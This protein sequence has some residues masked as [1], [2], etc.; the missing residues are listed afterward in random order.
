[1]HTHTH[2]HIYTYTHTYIYTHTNI[3]FVCDRHTYG[4]THTRIS[5]GSFARGRHAYHSVSTLDTLNLVKPAIITARDV[6]FCDAVQP[7]LPHR[8]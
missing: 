8:S 5:V 7:L 1:M 6:S 3:R 4:L 2:T